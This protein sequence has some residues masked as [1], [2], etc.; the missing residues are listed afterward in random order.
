MMSSRSLRV[1][2]Q[3]T[4]RHGAPGNRCLKETSPPARSGR[5]ARHKGLRIL[6]LI[7]AKRP[8]RFHLRWYT[9][10]VEALVKR[11]RDCRRSGESRTR[12][13]PRWVPP[14]PASGKAVDEHQVAGGLVYLGVED[15]AAVSRNGNPPDVWSGRAGQACNLLHRV[16]GEIVEPHLGHRSLGDEVDARCRGDPPRRVLDVRHSGKGSLLASPGRHSPDL[17]VHELL[18]VI[19]QPSV[20]RLERIPAA[21]PR[22]LKGGASVGA[23]LPD[24]V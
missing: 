10:G 6:L 5:D 14:A 22:N 20:G 21:T 18:G 11:P 16:G 12:F 3:G 17:G 19:E 4:P 23:H 7:G 8:W 13:P 15:V 24:L 1:L 2:R 9:G